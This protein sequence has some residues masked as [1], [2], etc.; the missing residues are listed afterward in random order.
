MAE[1][2]DQWKWG[3]LFVVVLAVFILVVDTTMMNVAIPNLVSDLDTSVDTVQAIIAIFAL[4][5]ASFM[6]LGAKVGEILGR[7]KAFLIGVG[8][9]TAGTLTAALSVNAFMLLIGWAILEGIAAAMMMPS[10][11]TFI[12]QRY[13][14][15]ER[16]MSFAIWGGVAAAGAA[17]GPIIGGF[18]TSYASWRWGFGMEAIICVAILATS[19]FLTETKPSMKWRHLDV[20]GVILSVVSM[21]LI[22]LAFL[23]SQTYGFFEPRL[24]FV[25][26]GRE[27]APLGISIVF[28]TMLT[29]L[30]LFVVF[31]LWQKRRVLRNKIP[32]FN[33]AVLGNW[34]FNIGIIEGV[35]QN[36]ALAGILFIFPVFLGSIHGYEAVEI[37]IFMM[38][39]SL[40]LLVVSLAGTKLS[41]YVR[42]IW[43]IA[44]GLVLMI[45]GN[46]IVKRTFEGDMADVWDLVPGT[47][48]FGLGGGLILSQLT[49]ATMGAVKKD[50]VPDASGLLNST[51]QLG[52]S[53]GTA[54]IGGVLM[55][56]AFT[57]MVDLLAEEPEFEGYD[58]DEV[59]LWLA[60]FLEKMN[61]GEI[62][63][64]WTPD[65]EERLL[66]I[67]DDA[68]ANGMVESLNAMNTTFAIGLVVLLGG[69]AIYSRQLKKQRESLLKS[70][71]DYNDVDFDQDE[72][73]RYHVDEDE[74]HPEEASGT[75]GEDTEVDPPDD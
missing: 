45:I 24:P 35:I 38:P 55:L 39:M 17:F 18:L 72:E 31:I 26:N 49:N 1:E 28:W 10:T 42:P 66:R 5:M 2:K 16:T 4:I 74:A 25:V 60:D 32:L 58:Q 64:N 65:Q 14:G 8:V 6:L 71:I 53:L 57:S 33:P 52:T 47:V 50:L 30:I 23:S 67:I 36:L 9:Y 54:I 12:T 48:V 70:E 62:E 11:T 46:N 56:T 29:G 59:A 34:G 13:S 69:A 51:R 20:V 68:T 22:V 19:F 43:M 61:Q 44:G 73:E 27:V 7:K 75:D 41:D 40:A 37:G 15:K 3:V 63:G 21:M